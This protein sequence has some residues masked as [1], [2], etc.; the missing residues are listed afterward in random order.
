MRTKSILDKIR[1]AFAMLIPDFVFHLLTSIRRPKSPLDKIRD[2]IAFSIPDFAFNFLSSII[3]HLLYLFI[4]EKWYVPTVMPPF[5]GSGETIRGYAG[6]SDERKKQAPITYDNYRLKKRPLFSILVPVCDPEPQWLW[7]CI[8]SIRS[9]TYSRWELILSDDGSNAEHVLTILNQARCASFRVRIITSKDRGGISTA[10]NKAAKIANGKYLVFLD[11]DDILDPYALK[12]FAVAI[13]A[14]KINGAVD[15]VYADEDFIYG[16]DGQ[17]FRAPSL[18]PKYSPDLLL[19]TN[20]MHHPIVIRTS[21]FK[22]LGGLRR[23]YDGSQD[24]DLLLRASEICEQTIHIHDILYHMRVHANSLSAGPQAKPDAHKLDRM[25]IKETLKRRGISGKVAQAPY[26][27]SGQN[28]IKRS[29]KENASVSVLIIPDG[30]SDPDDISRAWVNCQFLFGS[31]DLAIPEQINKL[32]RD[33][34]GEIIIV[35]GSEIRPKDGW[36]DAIVPHILRQDIGLVTG[37]IT[38]YDN[39]LF[40]CGLVLGINSTSGHWHHKWP[41]KKPGLAGWLTL[42]HEVSTVPWQFMGVRKSLFSKIG[43]LNTSYQHNG[44]VEDFALKLTIQHK[45][46]HLAIPGAEAIFVEGYPEDIKPWE[47][48]DR[49]LLWSNWG[50][51]LKQG[52]PFLNPNYARDPEIV[53]FTDKANIDL[54]PHWWPRVLREP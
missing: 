26:G 30:N 28:V 15:I 46:R 27:F 51:Y 24:H 5:I 34:E 35:A 38:Y 10:T 48:G 9:Q 20:Y 1:D 23:C 54:K 13:N 21:L 44:F 50:E 18:K 19:A 17:T 11:H 8:N 14:N 31:K 37:K 12:A 39:R 22:Q 42:D 53:K 49:A 36:E 32:A 47:E 40:S 33:A 2:A 7:D 41:A 45:L 25:L 3:R 52:D 43:G 6:W 16:K 4:N 29:I